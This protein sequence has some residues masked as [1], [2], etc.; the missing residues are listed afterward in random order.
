MRAGSRSPCA[1]TT[2]AGFRWCSHDLRRRTRVRIAARDERG[3][4][5]PRP[6]GR[7]RAGSRAND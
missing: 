2:P 3:P 4:V 7:G 1:T 5:G 6:Q